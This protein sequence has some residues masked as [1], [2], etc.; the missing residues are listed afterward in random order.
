MRVLGLDIG[1]GSCGWAVVDV[2]EIDPETGEI[3]GDF[4]IHACGVRGFEVPEEPDTHELRNKARRQKRGQRRLIRRRRQ[5]LAQIRR[6]LA[7]QGLPADP[8]PMRPGAPFDLVWRLRV[9][10]LDR[11]LEPEEWSRVLIHIARH[12]GFRSNSK[13]DRD[14]RSETGKALAAMQKT[15]QKYAGYRSFAEGV[16]NDKELGVRRRNRPGSYALTPLRDEL[17]REVEKLFAAQRRFGNPA[18]DEAFEQAFRRTAFDQR[19]LQGIEALIG[20]CRLIPGEKRA[21]KQ[22]PSFE[23]FR[24][25]QK[26]VNVRLV[27][28]VDRPRPLSDDERRRAAALFATQARVSWKTLRRA[29]GLPE[30]VHF[31]GLSSKKAD[32]ESEPLA[33]FPGSRAL[34]A[35]LGEGR[36]FELLDQAPERLDRAAEVLIREEDVE[37]IRSR[38][39]QTGFSP[40]EIER[41][42]ADA[43]LAD[44][45]RFGGTGHISTEACRRLIPHLLA[46]HDYVAA[47]A[48]AGFDAQAIVETRLEDVRNPVVQKVLRESLRQIEVVVRAYGEPDRVHIEMA[49]DMGRS[50]S[51]RREIEQAQE[52]RR[53]ERERH[54]AELRELLG[55]EPNDEEL[56]RYEL[57]KEQ[58]HRCPYTFPDEE[59][60]IPP[61]ALRA[62]D[63]RVQVDHIYPYSRSGDNSFRNKVLCW[64]TANQRKGR[65]TP[66]EWFHQD[67]PEL[68]EAFERR[69]DLWFASMPKEKRRKLMARGFADRETAYRARHLNDTRYAVRLLHTLLRQRWPTLD[70]R[71]LF[72]RPGQITAILRRAWGIDELKRQNILADRDHALDAIVVA[73]TSESLLNRLTRLHQELEESGSG[74]F[75]PHVET[76]LGASAEA[77]ER[78]RRLVSEKAEAVFVSRGE[79]R[80]GR[81]PLHGDTL[82]GF[83][84]RPDGTEIQYERRAVWELKPDDLRRLKDRDGRGRAVHDVLAAWLE[85]ARAAG[86]DVNSSR[87]EKVRRFWEENPPRLHN[88]RPIRRV[89]LVR[90]TTAGIKLRRGDGEAHADQQ[91]MV[92]VDV[93]RKDMQYYVVPIYAWQL[94][95][96][97]QPPMRAIKSGAPEEEWYEI[98]PEHE[99]LWS[100][101]P[102]S[103][104]SGTTADGRP[105]EGY[106]RRLDRSNGRISLSPPHNWDSAAQCRFATR[107][108]V[109]FEKWHV[110]R[111][112]Q[113][114]RIERETRTWRGER[115]SS[116]AGPGCA[117]TGSAASSS[118]R[119]VT[120]GSPSRT[121]PASSSTRPSS[122]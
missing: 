3:L 38:L 24:F 81:G 16:L 79:I 117:S 51:A 93:F 28:G 59:A 107:T 31:E 74:R 63:N 46:G 71:R 84:R 118:A 54:R 6:L 18:S 80:R 53:R 47:C 87:R 109:S 27:S 48:A 50:A 86:I 26:L 37:V 90:P 68:W 45:A 98:G 13:R 55:S 75:T 43:T 17:E 23:R 116:P 111:L 94:T 42:T 77:R 104:V 2:P 12:R 76:P 95:K 56:L 40:Q 14:N 36:F 113:R 19:P 65:R 15:A 30:Q 20:P 49:R 89:R 119:R 29:L 61:E 114:F 52:E 105:F 10:G 91:S 112:G 88:G 106:F 99:F 82:Y 60:Y 62:T 7:A 9:A 103:F 22:A 78:F 72:V 96:L 21:P 66:Y 57:W 8:G 33:E 92:R 83:E 70:R 102:G 100:L 73:C 5:R 69:V 58:D 85:R 4:M 39:A 41:L 35:A 44:F 120:S 101:Y 108:L 122:P 11:R 32:P 34:I 110:D 64:A 1:I 67:Q 97:A 121:S 25:L 115:C